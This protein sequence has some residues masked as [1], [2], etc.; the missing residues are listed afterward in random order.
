MEGWQAAWSRAPHF[1]AS[2]KQY[3]NQLSLCSIDKDGLTAAGSSFAAFSPED[4]K[5]AASLLKGLRTQLD[6]DERQSTYLEVV[7]KLSDPGD[8]ARGNKGSEN[9]AEPSSSTDSVPQAPVFRP[10]PSMQLFPRTRVCSTAML[11]LAVLSVLST[12]SLC[13]G[14]GVEP[15]ILLALSFDSF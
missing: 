8:T 4:S 11:R 10:S 12:H 13:F 15:V 1:A 7:G 3:L 5:E 9:A 6:S 2:T 14:S